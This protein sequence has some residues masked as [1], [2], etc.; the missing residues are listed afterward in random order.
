MS[1]GVFSHVPR[2]CWTDVL[3]EVTSGPQ[4]V[5]GRG[6]D[7]VEQQSEERRLTTILSAD[8]VGYSR[9]MGADEAGTLAVLKKH[10]REL[11]EPK[12]SQYRGRVVKLMG[13]GTLMEFGSVVDAVRFA[14]EV[15]HAMQERNADIAEERRI[16]F[17]I[18]INIITIDKREHSGI[19]TRR[20][21]LR[22]HC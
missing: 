21:S 12:T 7:P 1:V 3:I 14:V 17:R 5:P 18:G 13:D 15:Q 11:F 19:E 8:V 6:K 4:H 2:C 16:E 10:R 9:L 20:V 22:Y